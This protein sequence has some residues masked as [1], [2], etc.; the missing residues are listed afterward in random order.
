MRA[1]TPDK[2]GFILT[3]IP[4]DPTGIGGLARQVIQAT[5]IATAVT[6]A[7]T[8]AAQEARKTCTTTVHLKNQSTFSAV[9]DA[10]DIQRL[11]NTARV[12]HAIASIARTTASTLRLSH[13]ILAWKAARA[14]SAA[15]TAASYAT[16]TRLSMLNEVAPIHY[17]GRGE[18]FKLRDETTDAWTE[19]LCALRST[20]KRATRR[21]DYAGLSTHVVAS[22]AVHETRRLKDVFANGQ[23]S[24]T[25]NDGT[26]LV[27]ANQA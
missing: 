17:D 7:A 20:S 21:I 25:Q 3:Y 6:T 16:T 14:C 10:R 5:K 9:L 2:F 1:V 24:I 27:A 19:A 26:V 11:H 12:T 18:S 22:D 4:N 15:M 13:P 8:K 23:V